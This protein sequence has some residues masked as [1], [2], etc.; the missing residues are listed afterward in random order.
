MSATSIM[1]EEAAHRRLI[2]THA[3]LAPVPLTPELSIWQATDYAP[4][5]EATEAWLQQ[6]GL[7]PPFWAF[8]WAGGQAVARFILD[9]PHWV[10][11]KRTLDFAAGSGL[12]ALAAA[13]VGAS[14][15]VA[16]DI[17]PLAIAAIRLNADANGL[18]VAPHLHNALAVDEGPGAPLP[19]RGSAAPELIVAGDICYE[20]PFAEAALAWLRQW[21]AQGVVV[22][23]G[24][25]GRTYRPADGLQRLAR[26]CVPVSRALEG[27][28]EKVTDVWRVLA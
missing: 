22:L 3:C 14:E 11:G 18:S 7:A 16:I 25:P 13:R 4:L 9:E 23:L 2:R 26:F 20:R 12:I 19:F 6:Q 8:P 27:G 5:W 1:A 10:R 17:D 24:D 21:A 28:D 15:A